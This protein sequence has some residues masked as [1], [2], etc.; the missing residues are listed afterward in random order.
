ME[1]WERK[2]ALAVNAARSLARNEQYRLY[3]ELPPSEGRDYREGELCEL[4]DLLSQAK[5]HID[6]HCEV[7]WEYQTPLPF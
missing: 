2:A 7:L 5:T 1:T 6:P 3:R 4:L